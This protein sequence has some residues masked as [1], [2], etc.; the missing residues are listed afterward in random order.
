MGAERTAQLSHLLVRIT[1]RPTR[2]GGS[3]VEGL[4]VL[5][6]P[7]KLTYMQHWSA[8]ATNDLSGTSH[9]VQ[10]QPGSQSV[11]SNRTARGARNVLPES[12]QIWDSSVRSYLR[13]SK[14]RDVFK[15]LLNSFRTSCDER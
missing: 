12:C 3:Q 7:V 2:K 10:R 4:D 8:G 5:V 1:V 9:A 14:L 13:P 15:N 6:A 11:Y